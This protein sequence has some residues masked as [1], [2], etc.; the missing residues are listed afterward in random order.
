MA[1]KITFVTPKIDFIDDKIIENPNWIDSAKSNI[2]I[3]AMIKSTLDF[4]KKDKNKL[5]RTIKL[6]FIGKSGNG[7]NLSS[8]WKGAKELK[9]YADANTNIKYKGMHFDFITKDSSSKS[10]EFSKIKLGD[11]VFADWTSDGIIDHT[12]IVTNKSGNSYGGVSVTYQNASGYKE[13][14][15]ISLSAINKV[16]TVFYVYRP[17][18]YSD[19]GL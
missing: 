2:N 12:M 17:T 6:Y 10:L 19:N 3:Y 4:I 9:K 18:F 16:N 15:N 13:R 14:R 5:E 11:I 7:W 8:S 1:K